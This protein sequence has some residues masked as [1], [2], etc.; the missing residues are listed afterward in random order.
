M[1]LVK[2]VCKKCNENFRVWTEQDDKAWENGYVHCCPCK[3]GSIFP[4]LW[5]G[6]TP[7]D[8]CRFKM[9]QVVCQEKAEPLEFKIDWVLR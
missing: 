5:T 7:D 8:W 9:E 2:E 6:A 1:K 3:E 4:F